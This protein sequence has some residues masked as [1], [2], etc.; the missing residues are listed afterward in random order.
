MS[1]VNYKEEYE[2]AMDSLNRLY[3][4]NIKL[5]SANIKLKRDLFKAKVVVLSD[6][7]FCV[8][9]WKS[10]NSDYV[11]CGS[12]EHRLYGE[13]LGGGLWFDEEGRLIDY[14][15]VYELP[16]V[17]VDTLMSEDFIIQEH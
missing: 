14:D 17:V 10:T 15:G 2:I 9:V 16:T 5:S 11:D 7:E 3:L 1:E 13:E 6:D 4:E 12:F 8:K